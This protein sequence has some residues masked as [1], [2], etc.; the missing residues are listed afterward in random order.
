MGMNFCLFYGILNDFREI[1][2]KIDFA[3]VHIIVSL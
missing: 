1:V 2:I 3:V